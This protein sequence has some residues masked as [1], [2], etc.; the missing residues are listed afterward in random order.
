MRI[1]FSLIRPDVK[2]IH[3]VNYFLKYMV[4]P[5][6]CGSVSWLSSHKQRD[7]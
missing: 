2:E 1:W 7:S 4:N 6:W 5:D 3:N